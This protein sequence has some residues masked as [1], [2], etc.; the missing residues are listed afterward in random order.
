MIDDTAA[1][2]IRDMS[3][4]EILGQMTIM[5]VSGMPEL[6][7]DEVRKE[8]LAIQP[9]Q[10]ARRRVNPTSA[11]AA[12]ER[13]GAANLE[14]PDMVVDPYAPHVVRIYYRSMADELLCF[15]TT[16]PSARAHALAS[17]HYGSQI[18]S[19]SA[20]PFAIMNGARLVILPSQMESVPHS[21]T[22]GMNDCSQSGDSE[23]A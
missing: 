15:E 19:V 3:V 7:R 23:A 21:N 8:I 11:R 18:W 5:Y 16:L 13:R 10:R 4:T 9:R 12:H 20:P 6:A 14:Q 2:T 1:D 17:E 22:H